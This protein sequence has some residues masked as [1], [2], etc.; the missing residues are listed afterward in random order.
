MKMNKK[1]GVAAL[2]LFIS[3][4]SYAPVNAQETAETVNVTT[5]AEGGNWEFTDGVWSYTLNGVKQTGWLNLAGTWYYLN[6]SGVM[7]TGWL[8]LGGT[9]YYLDANGIMATG[10]LDLGGTWYYLDANGIMSTGWLNLGGTW[11]Y[12]DANGMMSTGWLNMGG[13]WYYLDAAG[14]MLTNTTVGRWEID[15]NGIA[16]KI[17]LDSLTQHDLEHLEHL[18]SNMNSYYDKSDFTNWDTL[19]LDGLIELGNEYLGENPVYPKPSRSELEN[20]IRVLYEVEEQLVAVELKP[21][22]RARLENALVMAKTDYLAGT[23]AGVNPADIFI[24]IEAWYD[25]RNIYH[26]IAFELAGDGDIYNSQVDFF[27]T[28]L[29]TPLARK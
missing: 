8:D 29:E 12:L 17:V 20:L 9:W 7:E 14:R 27:A 28:V 19:N 21:E 2:A 5:H 25:L 15:G 18:I 16:T 10:W 22:N 1:L 26:L 4:A 3:A 13:T 23:A 6:A 24:D 11:Y